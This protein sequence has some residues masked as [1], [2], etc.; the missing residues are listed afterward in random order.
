MV[1]KS[2]YRLISLIS[3]VMVGTSWSL[4]AGCRSIGEG[5]ERPDGLREL[6][7]SVE[8]GS[9][10]EKVEEERV[11]VITYVEELRSA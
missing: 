2:S 10:R 8:T 6:R 7:R 3:S 5:M 11:E 1:V 9:D 4:G